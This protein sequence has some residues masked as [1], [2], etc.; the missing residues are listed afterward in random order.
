MQ[1]VT[2]KFKRAIFIPPASRLQFGYIYFYDIFYTNG[3]VEN[4]T[5]EVFASD[6]L[7]MIWQLDFYGNGA[8][9]AEKIL[10]QFAKK[11]IIDKF[12]EGTLADREEV[13]LLTSTQPSVCPYKPEDLRDTK[14]EQFNIKEE[15]EFL[16]KE[17]KENI[18][19]ASII[20]TRDVINAMFS[21]KHGEKLLLLD[22]ERNLLDFFKTAK[23]VEDYSH[24]IASLG[25]ISRNLN[26]KILKQIL[27]EEGSTLGSVALLNKFLTTVG[28]Q[29][30]TVTDILKNIGYVRKGYPIHLD[31]ADVLKGYR[32]FNLDYPVVDFE[33]TWA[34]LVNQYWMALRQLY[35]ILAE[36]YSA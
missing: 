7:T 5:I 20:E 11:Q 33:K 4:K 23:T 9:D 12:K 13:V 19:A 6:V 1:N 26:V 35:E 17:I 16:F 24:R 29:N 36:T 14:D 3:K 30:N 25:Q 27:N 2:V 28:K 31:I 10:L 22:Q 32:Y 21:A 8:N 15:V 34:T 18:L